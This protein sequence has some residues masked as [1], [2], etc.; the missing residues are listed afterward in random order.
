MD[1]VSDGVGCHYIYGHCCVISDCPFKHLVFIA[2]ARELSLSCIICHVLL[3]G[4]S[5]FCSAV[6]SDFNPHCGST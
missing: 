3:T 6:I 2:A 4:R 1:E 5:L